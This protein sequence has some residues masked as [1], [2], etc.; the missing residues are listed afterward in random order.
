M[1]LKNGV[2]IFQR[3]IEFCLKDV[4]D[5]AD[6]YVDDV[7][8]GTKGVGGITP[9]V[10]RAHD[11]DIRRVLEALREHKMVAD[12]KKCKFFVKEVEFCG[13]ILGRGRRRPSP[14]K[15]MAL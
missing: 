1:G 2:A 4:S 7:I 15:L 3:V 9:E 12:I 5:V 8:T 11:T 14:G 10:L 6:P 13:H